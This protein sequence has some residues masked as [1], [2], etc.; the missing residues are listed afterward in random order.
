MASHA[1]IVGTVLTIFLNI[2][3]LVLLLYRRHLS[4]R[5]DTMARQGLSSNHPRFPLCDTPTPTRLHFSLPSPSIS[6]HP[7]PPSPNSLPPPSYTEA[8]AEANIAAL[9]HARRTGAPSPDQSRKFPFAIPTEACRAAIERLRRSDAPSQPEL[10]TSPQRTRSPV[11]RPG[12]VTAEE[13]ARRAG[14]ASPKEE[15][16]MERDVTEWGITIGDMEA[17]I[18]QLLRDKDEE[19]RMI[20]QTEARIQ[21]LLR[22]RHEVGDTANGTFR[23]GY[24]ATEREEDGRRGGG[25]EEGGRLGESGEKRR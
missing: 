25:V 15:E 12:L 2:S 23:P 8:G 17:K 19:W 1:I 22:D 10:Q 5:Y 11:R 4:H 3:L 21:R 7:L 18:Q 20:G 6:Y 16:I 9:I 14:V 24:I 13:E